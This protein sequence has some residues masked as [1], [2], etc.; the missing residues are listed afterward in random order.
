VFSEDV[1]EHIP[2]ATL[3]RLIARIASWLRPNGLALIRPNVFTGIL[4]GHLLELS[5]ASVKMSRFARLSDPWEHLR[6]RRFRPNTY[7]NEMTRAEYR[8]LFRN[9][10][11]ILEERVR[12]PNLG[13]AYLSPAARSDLADWTDDELFSNQTLFVLAPR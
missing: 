11:H 10:F 4:G 5:E 13:R 9:S 2:S 12:Q 7:L 8:A 1:F 3:A 6:G